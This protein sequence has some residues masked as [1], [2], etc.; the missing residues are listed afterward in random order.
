MGVTNSN[1][2][3]SPNQIACDGSLLVT[4]SLTA[5]PDIITDPTDIVLTLDRSSSMQG[6]PLANLKL[7]AKT[8]IDI[9][10][11]ATGG[12]ASG[13]IGYGSRIGIV[14]FASTAAVDTQLITD[15][16]TL[17]TAVDTLAAGGNTNHADAFTRADAL[18]DPTSTNTKVIVMFTD[19]KTTVGAPPAPV[20]E[21]AKAQGV[22]IY[23]IGL[24]GTDGVD[25][26]ALNQWATAPA[27]AHV[28]V[29]PD[30]ADL[31]EL[32]AELAR[33]LSK[34]GATNIV[35]EDTVTDDFVI[36]DISTP[37]KG[38]SVST[39]ERSLRW[40]ISQLGID[41]SETAQLQFTVR[42]TGQ[43]SG[44][45]PVDLSITY[46]DA[47]GNV[48]SFPSPSASVDCSAPPGPCPCPDPVEFTV[49]QCDNLVHEDVGDIYLDQQGQ[50]VQL[51]ATL[52]HVCPGKRVALA[53]VL[54]ELAQ[55]GTE[56]P[57]GMQTMTVPAHTGTACQDVRVSCIPF[58]VPGDASL[59]GITSG[60]GQRRFQARFLAHYM[61]TDLLCP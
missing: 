56:Y 54:T 1:K 19:G 41:A 30:A 8:F 51:S 17:K 37:S 15:V 31:E 12:T 11:D 14:S 40:S 60:C 23:C 47:E 24:V 44:F 26:D 25:V 9:I 39:G 34:P 35:I 18:F 27:D 13:Q 46:S 58:V 28:A 36:T 49:S 4:L 3:I 53:V 5:A 20:A 42:H 10:A 6:D 32:F 33:N 7:G 45:K 38:T 61:D 48:V 57:R 50:I 52:K 22:I 55:D 21:A 59:S 43:T 2:T 16:S 29:T